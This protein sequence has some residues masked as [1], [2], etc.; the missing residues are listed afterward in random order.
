MKK[1]LR[2]FLTSAA[3]L[4]LAACGSSSS[5]EKTDTSESSSDVTEIT[6]W[7]F[8]VFTQENADDGVGTYE[9]SIIEAFEKANPDIKVKLETIDFTSGPEKITTAIEAGTAPD[10][11]F[12]APGRIIT[13]GKSGKLA[14]LNDLFTDE[15]VADVNND[16]LIQASKAG[17]TAYMYPISSAPFYMALNKAMLEDAGVLDLVK[18][19]WTT[20]DFE[21]V[22]KALKDKGYNPG[23]LFANGQG[24]DQGTRAFL[25]NLYSGSVTD[26]EVTKYTTDQPN[27]VKALEKAAGWIK[28]GYMMNGSQYNGGDDIQNFA[29]GQTSYTILWAPSQNGIQAQLLEASKVE[30]VEVPFPS[31]DGKADLEYL[32]NGFAVFNN[33][34]EAKVAAAKKF[35]QFICD[36]EEWGPKN[37]V[38][39]GAFPVRTSYGKLY[40]TERMETI[41]TWTEYYSPY[42]NTI[43]GFAEMRALWFP[44][45]QAV[46]NG[47]E[48]AADALAN[49]TKQANETIT[50]AAQ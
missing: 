48:S 44:M 27:F 20:D 31:D 28:D 26:A 32:V 8:P 5:S 47:E 29:N 33:G 50:K 2:L 19:G 23:S 39:T 43:D 24:G 3:V 46:S 40:D 36:D 22:I 18:D 10:V 21:K 13:Y 25:A 7:A 45:L 1:F 35:I 16:N 6:W 42:Y 30:V 4:S 12:D 38:R 9:A 14:D 41:S 11:L 17:D 15:F 34:D 37:V 49:F